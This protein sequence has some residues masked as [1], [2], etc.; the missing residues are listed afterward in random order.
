MLP[1]LP[2]ARLSAWSPTAHSHPSWNFTVQM[3]RLLPGEKSPARPKGLT[4][5]TPPGS[6]LPGAFLEHLPSDLS[7]RISVSA[8]EENTEHRLFIP[9]YFFR[10]FKHRNKLS[11]EVWK[12]QSLQVFKTSLHHL[13]NKLMWF[14]CW[15]WS[16]QEFVLENLLKS[17]PTFQLNDSMILR[18]WLF[19]VRLCHPSYP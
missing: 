14:Q 5:P 9:F 12:S 7:H 11:R 8:L 19:K 16:E 15:P 18:K 6:C 10:I 2:S 13:F 3:G 4:S 1:T 17:L